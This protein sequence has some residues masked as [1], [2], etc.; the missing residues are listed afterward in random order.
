MQ[1]PLCAGDGL[2]TFIAAIYGGM[3]ADQ[4]IHLLKIVRT[5][6]LQ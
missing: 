1:I 5:A 6:P 3:P 4:Y 2:E